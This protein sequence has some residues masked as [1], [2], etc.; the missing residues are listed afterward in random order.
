M[1][2]FLAHSGWPL[3]GA[4]VNHGEGIAI[5]WARA[6][7]CKQ[8][9][10]PLGFGGGGR[11]GGVGSRVGTEVGL[12]QVGFG[13]MHAYSKMADSNSNS[14][15]SAGL[16]PPIDK[17]TSALNSL[18]QREKEIHTWFRGE[19]IFLLFSWWTKEASHHSLWM[20]GEKRYKIRL[21]RTMP[22]FAMV[23]CHQKD[24]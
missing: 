10:S 4:T 9:T 21:N 8:G 24:P 22:F 11:G 5:L 15:I 6:R 3:P 17:Y 1:V 19:S 14:S 7:K 13:N 16:P 18:V 23:T 2:R 20:I 12:R